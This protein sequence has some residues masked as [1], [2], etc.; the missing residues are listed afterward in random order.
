MNTEFKQD[1]WVDPPTIY[2]K[3]VQEKLNLMS[4]SEDAIPATL[5]YAQ[6]VMRIT[7]EQ[8]MPNLLRKYNNYDRSRKI[9]IIV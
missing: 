1:P 7:T 9:I 8:F 6:P 2:V 5:T 4:L 3:D